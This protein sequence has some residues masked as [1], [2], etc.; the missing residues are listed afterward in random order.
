MLNHLVVL[1]LNALPLAAPL[2]LAALA[3][4]FSERSGV[5]DISL[6][7]KMLTAAC[8]GAWVAGASHSA[9][10]GLAGGVIAAM[11]LSILHWLFTQHYR[12]DHVVERN[13]AERAGPG[14]DKL[15]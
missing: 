2:I 7:G 13:G 9:V 12:I 5:I 10:I 8:I 11:V 14:R 3:G 6:E 15:H 4:L 1:L